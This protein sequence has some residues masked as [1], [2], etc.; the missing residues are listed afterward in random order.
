MSAQPTPPLR[1]SQPNPRRSRRPRALLA[2]CSIVLT[3]GAAHAAPPGPPLP[4]G[5]PA[6]APIMDPA[7]QEATQ[8]VNRPTAQDLLGIAR[9]KDADPTGRALAAA[10]AAIASRKKLLGGALDPEM[11]PLLAQER[12]NIATARR[13]LSLTESKPEDH[14]AQAVALAQETTRWQAAS[15]GG[16][17]DAVDVTAPHHRLP[18]EAARALAA[19]YGAASTEEAAPQLARLDALPGPLRRAFARF[20]DGFSAFQAA[21]RVAF[22]GADAELLGDVMRRMQALADGAK[23]GG[24]P[25]DVLLAEG[26]AAAFS[27]LGLDFVSVLAARNAF[28]EDVLALRDAIEATPPSQTAASAPIQWWP[29]FS[30]EPDLADA[31][32][33][34]ADFYLLFDAGGN[35]TYLNNAGGS[36]SL[37]LAP[38]QDVGYAAAAIDLLGADRYV[39]GRSN[40]INGGGSLGSGFLLD[41]LGNDTY[42]AGGSGV[43]GGGSVGT[44]FLLDALG[45]DAYSGAPE[46][47]INGG[48]T[49]GLGMLVDH[50]S[51][52]NSFSGTNFGVNGGGSAAGIGSL[53]AVLSGSS[54]FGAG[55]AGT[56][57]GGSLGAV[58]FLLNQAGFGLGT[59]CTSYVAG[60]DGTNGGGTLGG[61]GYLMDVLP[62]SF[63]TAGTGGVNGGGGDS[64]AFVL[65]PVGGVGMLVEAGGN[66]QYRAGSQGVNGGGY[67]GGSGNLVDA[68]GSDLYVSGGSGTNGGGLLGAGFLAELD[69]S[70]VYSA[71]AQSGTNGGGS[72]GSGFL[73]DA[74]G[75]DRYAGTTLGSNGG[76]SL[77]VGYLYEATGSDSYTAGNSGTNGGGSLG[78]GELVDVAG[79]DTYAGG[80]TGTNGG[81]SLGVGQLI[82]LS[83]NDS[84]T[85]GSGGANGGGALGTGLLHD[86][87]GDDSYSDAEGGSGRNRTVVPKGTAGAQI[88][89]AP[90]LGPATTLVS[91]AAGAT[92]GFLAPQTFTVVAT[93]PDSTSTVGVA[94]QN[95]YVAH[96]EVKNSLGVPVSEFTTL[97]TASG[98]AASASPPVPIPPG[99]NY[100]W[101]ARA[102]DHT[103][104]L[105]APAG[106][107]VFHVAGPPANNAPAAPTLIAPADGKAF[108]LGEAMTF[109]VRA[110]DPDGNPYRGTVIV[111]Q[112]GIEVARFPTAVALSGQDSTGAVQ[113]PPGSYTWTAFATDVLNAQGPEQPTPRSFTVTG[114][115]GFPSDDCAAGSPLVDG[116][117]GGAYLK[118]RTHSPNA[119]TTSGCLRADAAGAGSG[120]KVQV[121]AAG[122]P[123]TI[124]PDQPGAK[125]PPPETPPPAGLASS[126]CQSNAG[127][128]H[129]NAEVGASHVWLYSWQESQTEAHLCLRVQ[130]VQN[131]GG[132][133]SV[134]AATTGTVVSVDTVDMTPCSIK[135]VD[136]PSIGLWHSPIGQTPVSVCVLV[137]DTGHQVRVAL[138]PG[139]EPP[140]LVTWTPD[141]GTPGPP[142]P[143][144]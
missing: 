59:C 6:D 118:V 52:G 47:G 120:G 27:S 141:P 28:L 62:H 131:L 136:D 142:L 135:L 93:D 48:G 88:D 44:G 140:S 113:L 45:T 71:A 49:F 21:S 11:A 114:A 94:V 130:G 128:R 124:W 139:G 69:G 17:L 102:V 98:Q 16:R 30:I 65:V 51:A 78:T 22:A 103:G 137:K 80:S 50:L 38:H 9:E 127:A 60:N 117:V 40:G 72:A 15:L 75:N 85:A 35:D 19:S 121:G 77:G 54:T 99:N 92:F 64:D 67:F 25:V 110:T 29:F 101:T 42:S 37:T 87:G 104:A 86:G 33:Y 115:A 5:A 34:N 123:L 3:V 43:N 91:P 2:L 138:D 12:R 39:S 7:V 68:V 134:D 143:P 57:G 95:T 84:Y 105:G 100:T 66:D 126:V 90:T 46:F 55:S 106:P 97:P 8:A 107:R 83:G 73:F 56:N 26:P 89:S 13:L 109:T 61:V 112:G 82:D 81:G 4:P 53:V 23:V 74:V 70:D 31:N 14:L 24:D 108:G 111:R 144:P 122:A 132:R 41:G 79:N 32:T 10:E 119:Q 76:G 20:I 63:Y 129:A 125:A 18:S 1:R 36:S 116:Y 96:I 133:L 58:G